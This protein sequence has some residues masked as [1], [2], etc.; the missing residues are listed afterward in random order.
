MLE[1]DPWHQ[2]DFWGYYSLGVK[3]TVKGKNLQDSCCKLYFKINLRLINVHIA[4][5]TDV[6][7]KFNVRFHDFMKR[8]KRDRVI[9]WW[10]Q[11]R[12]LYICIYLL[13]LWKYVQNGRTVTQDIVNYI[14]QWSET[15]GTLLWLLTFPGGNGNW[16]EW[17]AFATACM[18]VKSV[19]CGAEWTHRYEGYCHLCYS[20]I[21][22]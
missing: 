10:F 19:Q 16:S 3:F 8:E 12:K 13:N 21:R 4:S 18:F 22:N 5:V 11:N 14:I 6:F 15:R 1:F 9:P 2:A 17:G 7:S 20:M